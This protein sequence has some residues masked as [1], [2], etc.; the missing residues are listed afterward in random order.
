MIA[1][2]VDK[3]KTEFRDIGD[4][5]LSTRHAESAPPKSIGGYAIKRRIGKGGM[6]SVY[7]AEQDRPR[8]T[9]ALKV[10]HRGLGSRSIARRFEQEAELLAQLDH[11]GIAKV[12]AA[13]THAPRDLD[14]GPVPFFAME[15]VRGALPLIEY[16]KRHQLDTR[17]RLRLFVDV[18]DAVGHGHDKGVLHRDLKPANILVSDDGAVKVID[19]GVARSTE[20]AGD[21]TALTE[22]GQLVG[23]LQYMSPEQLDGDSTRLDARSDLY[24]LGLVLYELLCGL[25]P[26]KLHGKPIHEATKIIREL[27]PPRPGAIESSL[28]GDLDTICGRLLEKSPDDRYP[29]AAAVR[30]DVERHLA[31]E[32]IQARAT[33]TFGRLRRKA[34]RHRSMTAV[35]SAFALVLLVAGAVI[36]QLRAQVRSAVAERTRVEESERE[37]RREL[38]MLRH[39]LSAIL[40]S[41]VESSE[42]VG[43]GLLADDAVAAAAPILVAPAKAAMTVS[44][45]DKALVQLDELERRTRGQRGA[46]RVEVAENYER[47]ADLIQTAVAGADVGE[48]RLYHRSLE[49]TKE[50]DGATGVH[51][52]GEPEESWHAYRRRG[53]LLA[54]VG[55]YREAS[56]RLREAH[57][58]CSEAL[59]EAPSD[60]RRAAELAA[61]AVDLGDVRAHLLDFEGARSCY[62]QA[63]DLASTGAAKHIDRAA[64][65]R[66]VLLSAHEGDCEAA[67][68]EACRGTGEAG[69]EP[70]DARVVA[71]G[72]AVCGR[73][74]DAASVAREALQAI[75][76]R[77]PDL[78]SLR[79]EAALAAELA[80]YERRALMAPR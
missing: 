57:D 58:A 69:C 78:R 53:R 27:D 67:W 14:V 21:D 59:S 55:N 39:D 23:T 60:P 52:E 29:T 73:F 37:L 26:Y 72:H 79:L 43:L 49:V 44:R 46:L 61:I 2:K 42:E 1:T 64:R 41:E 71:L 18:L 45:I 4:D 38:E 33:T 5:A 40:G 63:R 22:H 10:M 66:L 9:V 36:L 80:D 15:Y 35:V 31:G 20:A 28:A 76:A 70:E 48:Q 51:Q 7:E 54:K 3:T 65:K 62:G 56:D 50:I 30:E 75:E 68:R 34:L 32:P 17:A 8:R 74:D 77:D 16:A 13:G 47:I 24:S 12:F 6:G 25:L 19:F 11:P